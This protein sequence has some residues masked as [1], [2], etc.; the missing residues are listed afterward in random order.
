MKTFVPFILSALAGASASKLLLLAIKRDGPFFG[1]F[2]SWLF[3]SLLALCTPYQ[4]LC[5][6]LFGFLFVK[7][8]DV[9]GLWPFGILAVL[10]FWGLYPW[11]NHAMPELLRFV[12][13]E[14]Y[15]KWYYLKTWST[16]V[17]TGDVN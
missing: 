9:E 4:F 16:L 12:Q 7:V 1:L 5:A 6:L 10:L 17:R 3:V 13:N 11:L 14:L 2:I 8:T 15:A